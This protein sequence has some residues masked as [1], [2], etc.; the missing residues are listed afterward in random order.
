MM[1][2]GPGDCPPPPAGS[3]PQL[4]THRLAHCF[5]GRPWLSVHL[6]P[7]QLR[8]EEGGLTHVLRKGRRWGAMKPSPAPSPLPPVPLTPR[9]HPHTWPSWVPSP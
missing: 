5:T 1:G 9:A 4:T 8:I 6:L 7:K 3:P 2:R